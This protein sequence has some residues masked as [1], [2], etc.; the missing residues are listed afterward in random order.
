[1]AFRTE[2]S[3]EQVVRPALA[4]AALLAAGLA[5][6][7]A[8][9]AAQ[10][11]AGAPPA[12]PLVERTYMV[13]RLVPSGYGGELTL[14]GAPRG[15]V[16][17]AGW[18]GQTIS[19]SARVTVAA[20]SEQDLEKLASVV[21]MSVDEGGPIVAVQTTGP[22][23]KATM[24]AA[25]NFPKALAKMPW[26]MDYTIRVPEYTSVQLGVVDGDV[27]VE[28]V[29]GAVAVTSIRG[30]VAIRNVGGF[31][32]VTA[33]EGD[34]TLATADRT[35]RGSGTDIVAAH[36]DIALDAPPEFGAFLDAK[37]QGGVHFVGVRNTEEGTEMRGTIGRGGSRLLLS[38]PAGRVTIRLAR[39][40]EPEDGEAPAQVFEKPRPPA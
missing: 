17:V 14:V 29:Y 6:G 13:E 7:G 16:R 15:D 1:M 11:A 22:H 18:R 38:A 26:R 19:I 12:R 24:K 36:G 35:W 33:G 5:P 2:D 10:G 4:L 21:G 25:K 3:G 20:P 40:E 37:A 9:P 30:S 32:K 34:V 8:A 27:E 31:T 23:D 28:G 39:P